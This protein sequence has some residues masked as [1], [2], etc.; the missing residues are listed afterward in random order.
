MDRFR[1]D[2]GV[3]GLPGRRD[4]AADGGRDQLDRQRRV[5]AAARPSGVLSRRP[6]PGIQPKV[7]RHTISADTA[8]TLTSIMEGSSGTATKAQ[9]PGYTIAAK[10][11]RLPS[12]SIIARTHYN[13]FVGS[14][15]REIA[16]AIIVVTDSPHA[17]PYTGVPSRRR[18]SS[19][20]QKR[21]W[22]IFGVAPTVNPARRC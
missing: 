12:S 5:H 19:E 11:A 22:F 15:P 21:R 16:L 9:I 20:S 17:G 3:D 4:A 8:A 7:E 1:T 10:Q 2:V 13:A 14:C 18:C 6:A